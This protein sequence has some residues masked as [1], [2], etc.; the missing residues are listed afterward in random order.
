[1]TQTPM[2]SKP[3][4]PKYRY[5]PLY[6]KYIVPKPL[7]RILKIAALVLCIGGLLSARKGK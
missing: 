5:S 1:M 3:K 6:G 4:K 7:Q 2:I